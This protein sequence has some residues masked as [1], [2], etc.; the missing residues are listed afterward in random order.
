[1]TVH[2]IRPSGSQVAKATRVALALMDIVGIPEPPH[3]HI[4]GGGQNITIDYT[5]AA[6]PAGDVRTAAALAGIPFV[7][8]FACE[9]I[10]GEDAIELRAQDYLDG[11]LRTFRAVVP[12]EP[13]GKS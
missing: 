2:P 10:S 9:T 8:E 13:Q 7:E 6:H 5:T 12:L 3:T 1:M 4:H 11:I